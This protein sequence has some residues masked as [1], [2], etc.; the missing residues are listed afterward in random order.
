MSKSIQAFLSEL[1]QLDIKLSVEEN[2]LK[3][4]APL[5]ALTPQLKAELTSRKA[6]IIAFLQENQGILV[7]KDIIKSQSIRQNLPLSF[8]QQRL[9]FLGELEGQNSTYNMP[10]VLNIEGNLNQEALEKSINQIIQRHESL[11]TRFETLNGEP[12][13]VIDIEGNLTVEIINLE[14]LEPA[15]KERRTKQL[16]EQEIQKPFNLS[17]DRLIRASLIKLGTK[18]HIFL[19]TMHHIISDGWSMGVFVQELTTLYS[20]YV[21]GKKTQLSPLKIQYADF[22]VW[23]R[24]WLSGENL[25]NKID[26]WKTKL[27]GLP[28]LLELPTDYARPP[29][30]TF[31]GSHYTFTVSHEL[32]QKLKRLTQD[33]DVTLFM[34]L[35][36]GFSLLLSRYSRQE[37]IAIGTP[38][39][40]RNRQEIEALIGFFLNTLIMRVNI[41]DN[42]TVKQL[43]QQVKKTCLGAYA[44]QEIPFEKLVEELKPE[45]NLSYSPLFQVMFILQNTPNQK[46]TLPG[47]TLSPLDVNF[48]VAKFDLT[49]SMEENESGIQGNWEYNTGLF[50]RET[51]ERMVNHFKILLKGMVS[52]PDEKV[53][54]LPLIAEVER[55]Q[56]LV[57]WNKTK[58]DYPKHKCI[59]QLFE[60]QAE[61]RPNAIAI[62]YEEKQLTYKE[63]NQ[64]ANQLAHY[65]IKLGIKPDNLVGICIERS[66]EMVI[67]LLGILKAG[68]AYVPIDPNYPTERINYVIK[69]SQMRGLLTQNQLIEE[70]TPIEIPLI[71]WQQEATTIN[72]YPSNN[73]TTS[74]TSQNLAYVIYTSGSTGKPKGV[75]IEH[76]SVVNFLNSMSK[77]PGLSQDDNL[78]AVTT[79]SFDIAALELY[80]PLIRGGTILLASQE[81]ASDGEKLA[82]LLQ[83]SCTT[84]MQATPATWRMLI[85]ANWTGKSNLKILCGGEALPTSLAEQ[86]HQSSRELWNVYGPTETTI[87][88]SVYCVKSLSKTLDIAKTVQSIGHPIDNT[89][90][91][92]LDSNLEPVPIGVA[93]ELYIGGDGLARG[94]LNRPELTAEKFIPNPFDPTGKTRLYKTGD[95]CRYLPDGNIE[96]IGRI[97]HQVKIRGFRIELGEIESLL[98]SHPEVQESVVIAR[99][100]QPGNKRLVA[101]IVT[102]EVGEDSLNQTLR[103]YL[104]GQLPDYMIPSAFVFI[105]KLPLTPNGK[106]DRKAL[107]APDFSAMAQADFVAPSTDRE[108]ILAQV[109]SEVLRI[110]KI[111]INSNFFELGGDSI[112]TIQI[113]ARAK[114]AGLRISPKQLFEHQ[115]IAELATVA[116]QTEELAVEQGILTGVAPLTPI[117]HWFFEQNLPEI[118]HWNQAVLLEVENNINPEQLNQAFKEVLEHHD[119]LRF[120]YEKVADNWQQSYQKA[121]SDFAVEI[122]DLSNINTAQQS[123]IIET[124][125][126]QVQKSLNLSRG[127]LIKIVLFH[128]GNKQPSRL[129]IVI[130]HLAIDGVSWRIL[131]EDLVTAYNQLD[132]EQEIALPFKTSSYRQWGNKLLEYADSDALKAELDYWQSQ[133]V[134]RKSLPLDYEGDRTQNTQASSADVTIVLSPEETEALLKKVPSAYNTQIND[135][136]LTALILTF[137]QWTGEKSLRLDLEGHGREDL[138]EGIDLSRTVGWFTSVFPVNLSLGQQGKNNPGEAIKE[139]KEQLRRIPKKGIGYGILR[140]LNPET[141]AKLT[142]LPQAQISF[143]Y[144]GQF[145]QIAAS[146]P[147]VGFAQESTGLSHSQQ[148]LRRH[149]ID[150]NGQIIAGQLRINWTFSNNF[151][152]RETI[153]KLADNYQ[154][155]LQFL[156]E[157]C[158]LPEAGGFTPSDFPVASFNQ[159]EVDYLLSQ[160]VDQSNIEDI[161]ALSPTQQGI[162]FHTLY[163]P[164]SSVYFEQSIIKLQGSLNPTALQYAWEQVIKRHPILRTAFYQKGLEQPVQVVFK[165][166]NLSWSELDWRSFS[167]TEQ[168]DNLKQLLSK[169][170]EQGFDLT[171]APLIRFTLIQL[172]ED[173]YQFVWSR[174]DILLD[175]WSGAILNQELWSFYY[176]Y[177]QQST[178]E[179]KLPRSYRNYIYWLQKQDL[180]QAERFWRE[181]LQGFTAPTPLISDAIAQLNEQSTEYKVKHGQLSRDVTEKLQLLAQ[182][183]RFTLNIMIQ[184][185]WAWLLSCYS[186]ESDVVF[187]TTVSGRP[188]ELEGVESMVGLFINT[189]PVRV[190]IPHQSSVIPWLQELNRQYREQDS[191][192][193]TPLSKIMEWSEV[194]RGQ[195]L[196]ESLVIFENYPFDDSSQSQDTNLKI[197]EGSAFERTNYPLLLLIAPGQELSFMVSYMANRFSEE[198]IERMLGHL[199]VILEAITAN[200]QVSLQ[201]LSPLTELEKQQILVN[202]NDTSRDYPEN[203]GLHQL[204]EAQVN[205]SP[206]AIAVKFEGESLTYGELNA[207]ANQLAHYLREQGLQPDNLVGIALERSLEMVIGLLGILKAGA[208]YVPIDPSYPGDRIAYMLEDSK[209][210]MLL[211]Q[212][213]L[214][215][216]LP[217]TDASLLCLDDDWKSLAT[218]ST[219]NPPHIGTVDH[220]AYMIYTSG[221]TGKP[222]GAMNCHRGIVNRLLWMQEAYQLEA[223]DRIL[224]KTPFSFDV[225]VW[226]FFWPLMTGAT[227]VVAKPEGHKDSAYLTNIIQQ[228][229]ITTLHF[230]PPMLQVFIEEPDISGCTSLKRVICSGEA[231]PYDLQERFF[232]HLDCELHN[233]YGPT[234]AAIDVSYWQCQP[235]STLKKVPIGR[236]VANTQLYILNQAL[237]PVP[238]GAVGELH[239]GGVQVGKGYLN[240]PQLTAEK[241]INDPF[242]Q[243]AEARLYKTGDLCRYLPDGNIEYLGRIDHQVKIRGFRIE[244]GEIEGVLTQHPDVRE[245]VVIVRQDHFDNKQLVAYVVSPLFPDDDEQ[246]MTIEGKLSQALR[247]YL[248]DKLPDY[249]IPFAF[250][251]LPSLPLTPNGKIDR[252]SLPIPTAFTRSS[253]QRFIPPRDGLEQQLVEIWEE[254]LNLAPISVQDSFFELGGHSLLAVRLIS[255]IS[256]VFDRLLPLATLFQH[257]TIEELA[258]LLRSS[259]TVSA[260]SPLVNIQPHGE[261][262]PFFCVPGVGGNVLYLYHLAKALGTNRPFYGLQ[263]IGLDGKTNP[264]T[265]IEAIAAEYIKIIQT[266]QPEGPYLLAGHSFGASIAF[267]MAKQL[268]QQGEKIDLVAIFDALAPQNQTKEFGQDWDDADWIYNISQIINKLQKLNIEMSTEQLRKLSYEGQLEYF[269]TYLEQA[270]VI[271][272]QGDIRQV[273]GLLE[274]FKTNSQIVYSPQ[275]SISGNLAVFRAKD[276]DEIT[277]MVETSDPSLGWQQWTSQSMQIQTIPGDHL[278]IMSPPH[279]QVLADALNQSIRLA[280]EM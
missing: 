101:Y 104:K 31:Q 35:L 200:P 158:Q 277:S 184:A 273:K 211:T 51:I 181:K 268:E 110:E 77:Q 1:N 185:A 80:L 255:K 19:I 120:K 75:Q 122:K 209:V 141:Q 177:E 96:Y 275:D 20:G 206:Q 126:N 146:P 205:Q 258:N 162:L 60:Q 121:D 280:K 118:Y 168:K 261:G 245:V 24:E 117:Q 85:A 114:Q 236:P 105:E 103:D 131:L 217:V 144:L 44:H 171:Q 27:S 57:E 189:L 76:Q 264:L 190:T 50:K 251:L 18:N 74:V 79:I 274:V 37:D 48:N 238:V 7:T 203:Q 78:V 197:V 94:Y 249:M 61:K 260:W 265:R 183:H 241:F 259:D 89:Q 68:G 4:N 34:I 47:L 107:P 10:S 65:L 71:N 179:L 244:L 128:L 176:A 132:Q 235:N 191:Y 17:Q 160:I 187:G 198:T 109:W 150:I 270:Q 16:I 82:H 90:M 207:K 243:D 215:D 279:V 210:S 84:I 138:F 135:I 32:T 219:D 161:Y 227:L 21:E 91:Y 174:H 194:A 137:E 272:P 53:G 127:E 269:K 108:Q 26:Y 125:A 30:Q 248:K 267:E 14:S 102:Q 130:H 115:T 213:K 46:L 41:E 233:L 66:L 222:K 133:S 73:V 195:E 226:E 237:K 3:L 129:L 166:V 152:R 29:K 38:I 224:Q 116:Q 242:S 23:Q 52:N 13:Q 232:A 62:V 143:N 59:H 28:P 204:I 193:Y 156:I 9:W 33:S 229:Q 111:S 86:L 262:T 112:L 140:Y 157:H 113:V 58:A 119:A 5:G 257:S 263:S 153:Q 252:R 39:A 223:S 170:R 136:L 54:K 247:D 40:N 11:R 169:D 159:Q 92:L 6:D 67:G 87:W 186:G 81:T 218:Y 124:E 220:L 230:V 167:I 93:G 165:Q 180:S 2:K 25:Q 199:S 253:Q 95:L 278:T 214:V 240:R 142:N 149:L 45:R 98:T 164:E 8:A 239:I 64:K 228:E 83:N 271:A 63:L 139:I 88:S 234:E 49:L 155:N 188:P 12:I 43:L 70:L 172:S 173:T 175:G 55:Q 154:K 221:S 123:K 145:D 212:G 250:V 69:D 72:T 97:D 182:E 201:E 256:E 42:L 22:A 254:I 178:L 147:I 148:C 106:I 100:D 15:K 216:Q 196:F 192:F 208:A 163:S 202:W 36:S 231:L 266:V 56:F 225:S 151:H 99:E 276:S 134:T 246:V